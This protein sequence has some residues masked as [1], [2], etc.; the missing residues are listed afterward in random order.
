MNAASIG[1]MER[2]KR[3]APPA[4]PTLSQ[5]CDLA[6]A[7]A[8]KRG[9]GTKGMHDLIYWPFASPPDG[10]LR[11]FVGEANYFKRKARAILEE[12]AI[13]RGWIPQ[14]PQEEPLP[15]GAY[16]PGPLPELKPEPEAESEPA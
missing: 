4:P 14:T 1:G 6:W 13:K 2:K 9:R 7:L 16:I 12:R 8:K 15:G 11:F 5:V 10:D 3:R